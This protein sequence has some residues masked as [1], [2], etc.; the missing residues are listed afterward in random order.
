MNEEHKIQNV[1]WTP[2]TTSLTRKG[3]CMFARTEEFLKNPKQTINHG[4]FR[5]A[6]PG[7]WGGSRR[8]IFFTYLKAR[9]GGRE[10]EGR[11]WGRDASKG[12]W[13]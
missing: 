5:G 11:G 10:R 9:G 13:A 7:V 12:V 2:H 8:L 3:A 4:C 6:V 1:D